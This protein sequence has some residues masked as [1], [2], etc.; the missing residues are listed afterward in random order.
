MSITLVQY[1]NSSQFPFNSHN[2]E[3]TL[4][5]PPSSILVAIEESQDKI[6][7]QK[8]MVH[9]GKK[10]P[11]WPGSH[12]GD[13]VAS[14]C[15]SHTRVLTRWTTRNLY[16]SEEEDRPVMPARRRRRRVYEEAAQQ[17]YSQRKG[18]KQTSSMEPTA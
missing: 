2:E 12:R 17:P 3:N 4:P 16:D 13:S 1:R 14:A 10:G 7:I 5:Q 18:L 6:Q 11:L 8:K 9:K 15:H